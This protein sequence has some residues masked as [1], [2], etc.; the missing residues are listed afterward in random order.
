RYPTIAASS[1]KPSAQP[2]LFD[3]TPL[4]VP[5]ARQTTRR[6]QSM[7]HDPAIGG[8][9]AAAAA[10]YDGSRD[11]SHTSRSSS[12]C[13]YSD[14]GSRASTRRTTVSG[15][16]ASPNISIRASV[17]DP[18]KSRAASRGSRIS[19]G[20]SNNNTRRHSLRNSP[21]SIILISG[22]ENVGLDDG[23]DDEETPNN[24]PADFAPAHRQP[25][26]GISDID[27]QPTITAGVQLSF[28][29]SPSAVGASG[30]DTRSGSLGYRGVRNDG[31]G[32]RRGSIRAALYA[33]DE[34]LHIETAPLDPTG[35]SAGAAS[36]TSSVAASPTGT[37]KARPVSF[38]RAGV[39]VPVP[40]SAT[41]P[42]IQR[43]LSSSDSHAT[44]LQPP[45]RN[46]SLSQTPT[47]RT[48][49]LPVVSTEA[50]RLDEDDLHHNTTSASTSSEV[51]QRTRDSLV[52]KLKCK[53]AC[54][55]VPA[56]CG[57]L[58]DV[59]I[60]ATN[61]D[62][63]PD[64]LGDNT[65]REGESYSMQARLT[66][67]SMMIENV[68]KSVDASKVLSSAE[69][70]R[71]S[72]E[73]ASLKARLQSARTRLALEVRM[74]DTAKNLADLHRGNG[75]GMSMFK[76]KNSHQTHVDEYNQANEKVQQ[77]E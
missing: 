76:G 2:S 27:H 53:S 77:A 34:G 5:G 25:P 60:K 41:I 38:R 8:Y 10:A 40:T 21:Q 49:V 45:G 46:R 29:Q 74:R 69:Y 30:T 72:L 1:A 50:R 23:S 67:A 58:D 9:A 73:A 43:S 56:G 7:V 18:V 31:L 47:P 26:R 51:H 65:G 19:G 33:S 6:P 44:R 55:T 70:E 12:R 52:S 66:A 24:T 42:S 59:L 4:N 39:V 36:N 62:I 3:S 16:S 61:A 20:S 37:H 13:N 68:F 75:V 35:I 11:S 71:Y 48:H 32:R 63:P 54:M 17:V 28:P 14:A 15:A 22:Q 64:E 57:Y